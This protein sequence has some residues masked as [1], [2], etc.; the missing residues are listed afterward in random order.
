MVS[1]VRRIKV[2]ACFLLSTQP[3]L[4]NR[5]FAT[6]ASSNRHRPVHMSLCC[7]AELTSP[8]LESEEARSVSVS[9]SRAFPLASVS[10]PL[11]SLSFGNRA[12]FC[13]TDT[14]ATLS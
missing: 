11:A 14:F 12:A 13:S 2:R 10:S 8:E 5:F 4:D 1:E 7:L 9:D 3:L 6:S